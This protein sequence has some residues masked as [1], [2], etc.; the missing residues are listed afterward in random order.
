MQSFVINTYNNNDIDVPLNISI[1]YKS[2]GW[3]NFRRGHFTIDEFGNRLFHYGSSFIMAPFG[4][5]LYNNNEYCIRSSGTG[6][7]F[8]IN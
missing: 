1:E 6:K 5:I 4:N 8:Q 7:M 3:K 2:S